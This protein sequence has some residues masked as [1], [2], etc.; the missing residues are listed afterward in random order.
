MGQFKRILPMRK[1]AV[2]GVC[3]SVWLLGC[4]EADPTT[5]PIEANIKRTAALQIA[6]AVGGRNERGIEDDILRM[7]A[8]VPGLGGV[9]KENGKIIVL[10]PQTAVSATVMAGLARASSL[11]T[12]DPITRGNIARG[13]RI[14]LRPATYSFSQLI[15]WEELVGGAMNRSGHISFTDADERTNRVSIGITSDQYRGEVVAAAQKTG[16]PVDAIDIQV[17]PLERP[18]STLRSKWNSSSNPTKGGVQ[19]AN[20]G[21]GIC[22]LGWNVHRGPDFPDDGAEEGFFTTGHCVYGQPG[23]GITGPIYQPLS[24]QIG[25]ITQNPAWN[26]SNA[27]CDYA[28]CT[29]VD[30]MYVTYDDPSISSKTLAQTSSVGL[31]NTNGSITYSGIWANLT[32]TNYSFFVGDYV[33]KMGR[34]TGWTRGTLYATCQKTNVGASGYSSWTVLCANKV[35]GAAFGQGDSGGPVFQI[36]EGGVIVRQGTLFSGTGSFDQNEEGFLY[37]SADCIYSYNT[38]TRIMLFLPEPPY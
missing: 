33:D 30:A 32:G 2:I 10:V 23:A 31:S 8:E 3:T 25:Y 21:S 5:G 29:Q 11:L 15:V 18:M 37:C 16:V 36:G 19:I 35:S 20:A 27:L 22:T 34:T 26:V 24:T 38:M 13:E 4:A 14:E 1:R 28:Y 6:A 9:F 17:R 7:E 12:V